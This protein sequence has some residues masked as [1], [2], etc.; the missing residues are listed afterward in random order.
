MGK[1]ILTALGMGLVLLPGLIWARCSAM[2]SSSY[3]EARPGFSFYPMVASPGPT[4]SFNRPNPVEMAAARKRAEELRKQKLEKLVASLSSREEQARVAATERRR[5]NLESQFN[6]AYQAPPEQREATAKEMFEKGQAAERARSI[7]AARDY[8]LFAMQLAPGTAIALQAHEALLRL[9]AMEGKSK[10]FARDPG[11]GSTNLLSRRDL[12]EI[13]RQAGESYAESDLVEQMLEQ[14]G[15]D[16]DERKQRLILERLRDTK[17]TAYTDGLVRALPIVAETLRQEARDALT[18]RMVR[19]TPASLRAR[20]SSGPDELRGASIRAAA[21]KKSKELVPDLIELL[22][23]GNSSIRQEAHAA[24][25]ETT[26]EDFGPG[27]GAS[28]VEQFDA[29]K[30]WRAWWQSKSGK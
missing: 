10:G 21:R 6:R 1:W 28:T 27:R 5:D 3:R 12:E 2:R 19:M 4:F 9:D 24:L 29:R 18:E 20:M 26:G 23:D 15:S 17:G 14:L 8:Y 30:Q 16:P 7:E 22:I 13:R 25:K 11:A